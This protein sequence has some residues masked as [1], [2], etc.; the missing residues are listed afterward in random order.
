MRGRTLSFNGDPFADPPETAAEI[1]RRGA[2]V[3]ENGRIVDCG[4]ADQVMHRQRKQ[5]C[6]V[7]DYGD[8]LIMPGFI[9]SHAHFAQTRIIASWGARLLDWLHNYT[10][11]EEVRFGEKSYASAVASDYLDLLTSNG[12]T[13]VCTYGTVHTESVDA[14]FE[15][16][17]E[18]KMRVFAGKT[19]MDRNAPSALLD[20]AESAYHDSKS[21]LLKWNRRGRLSYVITPRFAVTSSSEQLCALGELW[22]EFPDCLMQ[23]HISEQLEE[24]QYVQSL[25]SGHQDYLAIYE[26]HGLL[27]PNGLYG[28]AIH[29]TPDERRRVSSAGA[30]LIHC[31]TSN[32]FI[33]SGLFDVHARKSENIK[34]GLAT[35]TGGGSSF[36]MLTTMAAAYEIAQLNGNALHPAQLLWLAT[37]GNAAALQLESKIGNLEKGLEA[38]CVVLNLRSTAAIAQRARQAESDWEEIFPTIMMGDERAIRSVWISGQLVPFASN[39]G[40][41]LVPNILSPASPSPGRM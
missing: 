25:F 1:N 27:K 28:H 32:L 41:H 21:L 9:D 12:T 16:A 29:L 34:V 13:T 38:D 26:S 33:G 5:K 20:T 15:A 8:D 24:I 6:T 3:F 19:C 30:T 37:R 7:L 23:T 4:D 18:R 22:S 31:P 2:V 10:F 14:F 39:T 17:E 11:P 40:T 36:S 35:D